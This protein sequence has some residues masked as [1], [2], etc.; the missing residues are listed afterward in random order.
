MAILCG[1]TVDAFAQ[2]D[3]STAILLQSPNTAA[4]ERPDN[5]LDNGRYVVKTPPQSTKAKQKSN[6]TPVPSASPTP[7]AAATPVP[8]PS[9]EDSTKVEGPSFADTFKDLVWGGTVDRLNQYKDQL[10]VDDPRQNVL[11][12]SLAPT[13]YYIESSS[14]YW[15]RRLRSSSPGLTTE[16]NIWMTPFIGL[17]LGYFTTFAADVTNNPTGSAG[18]P[19]RVLTDHQ[20]SSVNL[21][22]RKYFSMS[23][24][25]PSVIFGL[26]YNEYQMTVPQNSTYRIRL[27]ET[28]LAL[29]LKLSAPTSNTHA[30]TMGSEIIPRLAVKEKTTAAS[31]TSGDSPTSYAVKFSFGEDFNLDRKNR[32]YWRLS[33]RIEKEVY[34]GTATVDDPI[35]SSKPSG[36]SVNS[37]AT[38]FEFGYSWG[39]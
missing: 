9:P 13:F 28:G 19:Q 38:F 12:L 4:S 37:G 16:A 22:Y 1:F 21:T 25:S 5:N 8:T 35:T 2:L 7:V 14:D 17:N 24:R 10:Q 11:S 3:P 39:G 18:V 27:Q 30:W 20:Y 34:T 36:V 32:V 29:S 15:F 6:P 33:H 23:R 31:A 26:G